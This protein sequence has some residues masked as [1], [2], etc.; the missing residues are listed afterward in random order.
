MSRSR[1]AMNPTPVQ[2][3][4]YGLLVAAQVT[5]LTGVR[6]QDGVSWGP[7]QCGVS[8]RTVV[9]CFGMTDPLD[10]NRS[11]DV[12]SSDPFLVWASDECSPFGS[13]ARDWQGNARR[14]L[15][16]TQSYE[17]ANELWTGRLQQ[18][19][20]DQEGGFLSD[21]STLDVSYTGV[22]NAVDALACA[23]QALA[24]CGQGR[25]GM[26]HVTPQALVHLVT[27]NTVRRE[28]TQFLTPLGNVV[29][30]DAGYDGSGPANEPPSTTQWLYATGMISVVIE[31]QAELNP[32]DLASA[33]TLAQALDRSD[34]TITVYA[35]R[36]A[37]Y[38]WDRCC[39]I[40][41]EFALPVCAVGS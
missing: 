15:E 37:M 16:A 5:P 40:G 10:G 7:E 27:N 13:M 32:P 29:V 9:D 33:Q 24:R 36:L 41:V 17:I 6:W 11:P 3:P 18:T 35:Q 39:H 8:G 14:Q 12:V 28:G 23:E 20:A 21:H 30:A 31:A 38:L 34:N 1:Q 22:G 26:V 4:L 2:P 25:R 19:E